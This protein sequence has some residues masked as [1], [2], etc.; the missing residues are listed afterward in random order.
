MK[1]L[2][3]G[4]GRLGSVVTAVCHKNVPEHLLGPNRDGNDYL[5]GAVALDFIPPRMSQPPVEL[6]K[7]ILSLTDSATIQL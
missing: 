6:E 2:F 1:Q 7:G 4:E 5:L 3:K